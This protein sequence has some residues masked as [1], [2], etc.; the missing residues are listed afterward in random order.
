MF[1]ANDG[2]SVGHVMRT[3]AIARGLRRRAATRE[4]ALQPLFVTTSEASALLA[5]EPLATVRLPAPAA[6][7]RAGFTDLERRRLVRGT[8]L[9]VVETFA[10][11][12]VV[13]DTFP[14]GP[15]GE[16]A[17]IRAREHVLVRRDVP[18]ARAGDPALV[19]GIEPYSLAIVAD[20]PGRSSASLPIP[21]VVRVPPITMF[22]RD[23]M[24]SRRDARAALGLPAEGRILLVTSGGGGDEEGLARAHDIASMIA[25]IAPDVALALALGPLA[26]ARRAP[27]GATVLSR[28]LLAPFFAA[29]DGAIAPAGYNT[30]H[31]LAKAAVPTA[32]FAQPRPFDDQSARARR[33][34]D[35]SLALALERIDA[36]SLEQ[37]LAW[38][39]TASIG[40]VEPGG[41]DRA[42]DA[43][44]D[45]VMSPRSRG[46][47]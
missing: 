12:L 29:F 14:S 40:A 36:A 37:A 24:M 17:G 6:A 18:D 16:L 9:G 35:A 11:D 45:H 25:A 41:A 38:M 44:L 23:D 31:E 21:D 10:P 30:A 19:D 34:A 13:V 1:V 32:L 7:R 27:D 46:R 33:F 2:L 5:E 4:I 28:P 8:V 26:R 20:D 42:A 39:T 3:L 15:H 22:E 43:I 47:A